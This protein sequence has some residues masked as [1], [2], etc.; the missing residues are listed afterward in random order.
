M[1]SINRSKH[2]EEL[3]RQKGQ[4]C[5]E[6][7]AA[8]F[9]EC[10]QHSQQNKGWLVITVSGRGKLSCRLERVPQMGLRTQLRVLVPLLILGHIAA[11]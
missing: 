7:G 3:A 4:R 8:G 9:G 6:N 1:P 11:G 5:C 2:L 10:Q